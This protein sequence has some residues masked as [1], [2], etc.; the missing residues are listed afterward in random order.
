MPTELSGTYVPNVPQANQQINNTQ[1][2]IETNFEDIAELIEVNHIPFNTVDDF[3]KHN[4]VTYYNQSVAPGASTDQMVL[5]S[6]TESDGTQLYYQY[7]NIS[8][9][10]QLTGT[11]PTSSGQSSYNGS[12]GM[13]QISSSGLSVYGFQFLSGSI[14]M[15]FGEITLN[16]GSTGSTGVTGTYTFNFVQ[17]NQP[18]FSQTPFYLEVIPAITSGYSTSYFYPE[19]S[20]FVKTNI[21]NNLTF[22][23]NITNGYYCVYRYM[24]MGIV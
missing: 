1:Q 9:V 24:A 16:T 4:F 5:F 11:T 21:I 14:C 6:Q 20:G 23:V 10:Y 22:S 3:G 12:T 18:E 7:P 8:T 19:D 17:A 15:V 13:V 2:P